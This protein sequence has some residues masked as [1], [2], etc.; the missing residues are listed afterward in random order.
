MAGCGSLTV[1]FATVSISEWID[2]GSS[3]Y[4]FD[5]F[6]KDD[7]EGTRVVLEKWYKLDGTSATLPTLHLANVKDFLWVS[8]PFCSMR[9]ASCLLLMAVSTPT[10]CLD[11][12]CFLKNRA[13]PLWI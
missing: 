3:S 5:P 4:G 11:D 9:R 6:H 12:I 10:F 2:N 7:G 8:D 1:H 13:F